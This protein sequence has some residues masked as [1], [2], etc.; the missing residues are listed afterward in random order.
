MKWETVFLILLTSI[1]VSVLFFPMLPHARPYHRCISFKGG[2][3]GQMGNMS[4]IFVSIASY[5]DYEC[6][7][8]V[9]SLFEQ[10]TFPTRVYVGI[11]EQNKDANE[12]CVVE[13]VVRG[14]IEQIS[15][16]YDEAKG[17]CYARYL[18]AT[19]YKQQDLF[20]QIDS[21]T[22]FVKGWDEKVVKMVN[23]MPVQDYKGI[24][25]HYPLDCT[26]DCDMSH[27]GTA[28]VPV[29]SFAK[30]DHGPTFRCDHFEPPGSY[31]TSR[32]VGGGFLLMHRNAINA[33]PYD[34][35]LL[36]VF[37][38]EEILQAARF[39]THGFDLFAP[40]ENIVCHRYTYEEHK[41]PWN[42]ANPT[43]N[44]KNG[45]ATTGNQRCD[46]LLLGLLEGDPYGMGTERTLAEFW[47]YIGI[48]YKAKTVREFHVQQ[49]SS[50]HKTY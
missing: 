26:K 21:H 23:D 4:T 31:V 3:D 29:L 42:E 35:D 20:L 50:P 33:C 5:R 18:C 24:L 19:M 14:R 45:Q 43:W 10:A 48:D 16:P 46:D 15:I 7:K 37:D 12:C 27:I 25:T 34:P 13:P 1:L 9:H 36:G 11:C 22:R 49:Y 38:R 17:P 8:T 30:L 28:H 32:S 44:K 6:K 39:Y 41:V 40:T 2:K 47:N